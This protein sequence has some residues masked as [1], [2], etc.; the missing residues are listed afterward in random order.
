MKT[1][2]LIGMTIMMV[3]VASCFI[4][5]SS[6]DDG[7]GGGGSASASKI[8]GTWNL[9]HFAKDKNGSKADRDIPTGFVDGA[10]RITFK[11]DGTYV[12]QIYEEDEGWRNSSYY[13]SSSTGEWEVS[14][15][16]LYMK[17][18]YEADLYEIKSFNGK[19]MVLRYVSAGQNSWFEYTYQKQ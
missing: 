7:D 15:S 12:A 17:D 19:K 13:L 8:E 5:C 14:G 6:D 9:I 3:L 11:R 16:T 2:R 10:Y 18:D 4:A 1:L